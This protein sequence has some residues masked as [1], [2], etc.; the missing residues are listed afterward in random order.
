[1]NL[2]YVLCDVQADPCMINAA[3]LS[4]PLRMS[5]APAAGHT[6]VPGGREIIAAVG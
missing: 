1:M 5:A 3:R 2:E 4:N 6:L